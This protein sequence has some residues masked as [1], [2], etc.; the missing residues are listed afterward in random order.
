[1]PDARP[2]RLHVGHAV[3]AQQ[4]EIVDD[5]PPQDRPVFGRGGATEGSS[6]LQ[7]MPDCSARCRGR[8]S[9]GD[10]VFQPLK[11]NTSPLPTMSRLGDTCGIAVPGVAPDVMLAQG[12]A[13]SSQ[14]SYL[15]DSDTRVRK[16][17]TL[18]SST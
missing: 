3:S 7:K 12:R 18:P 11:G 4:R 16:A 8:F 13:D 1:C 5:A 2:H 17:A 15:K 10:Q 9:L 14:A 6:R